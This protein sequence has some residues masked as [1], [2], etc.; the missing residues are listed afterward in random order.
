MTG[1]VFHVPTRPYTPIDSLNRMAAALGSPRYG[2][3]A[4]HANYNGHHVNVWWNDYRSY[5]IAEYTW[6]GRVVIARG[7]F[8]SCLA[9]A[10][11]EHANGALGA[12]TH[13]EPRP[14]DAE[15]IALCEQT[16]ELLPGREPSE[17]AWYT[18]KH[19]V[20]AAAA[21]D[22]ANPGRGAMVF[23]WDLL[24]AAETQTEYEQAVRAKHGRVY[25]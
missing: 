18:W 12:S 22:S 19:S 15:A 5:Y 16:P 3:A 11:R 14:D 13:V 20:G 4:A 21:R 10:L 23:D 1:A 17:R 6:A 9:A 8:A 24:Q 25:T 7:T 2:Q